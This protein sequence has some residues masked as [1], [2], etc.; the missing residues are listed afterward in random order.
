MPDLS[1]LTEEERKIILAV[2][3]RQKKE[4][5]KEQSVLKF[6][7]LYCRQITA[8]VLFT[9]RLFPPELKHWSNGKWGRGQAVRI[10][11]GSAHKKHLSTLPE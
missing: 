9:F 8:S 3:D 1:H 11:F 2:M 5:E 6:I 10:V 4:E 7:I